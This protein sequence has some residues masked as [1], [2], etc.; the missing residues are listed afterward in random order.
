MTSIKDYIKGIER[1]LRNVTANDGHALAKQSILSQVN[2]LGNIAQ[3][4]YKLM[5]SGI[6]NEI[7][8][9]AK[10]H[11]IDV[12]V[13]YGGV[14]TTTKMISI[15]ELKSIL[16]EV[17]DGDDIEADADTDRGISIE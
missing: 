9:L 15:D 7:E 14:Q 4:S 5:K 12:P 10:F 13:S 16:Y 3:N 17:F 1:D 6:A 2:R 8:E 11:T